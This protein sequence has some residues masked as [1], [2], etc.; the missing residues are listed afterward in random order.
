MAADVKSRVF[1]PFF[2]TKGDG[3]GTG[4]GLNQICG[5]VERSGGHIRLDSETGV[6]TAVHLFLPKWTEDNLASI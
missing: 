3:Y 6:G 2:T 5:F 4:L 1:E